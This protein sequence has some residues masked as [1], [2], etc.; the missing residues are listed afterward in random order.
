MDA[1]IAWGHGTQTDGTPDCGCSYNGVSE[2]ELMGPIASALVAELRYHGLTVG[3]D[4][5]T[6]NDRNM[7]YTVRD[8]NGGGAK[9]Y[10]SVHCDFYLAPSGTYPICHP[11]SPE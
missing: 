2:A 8:A 9:I 3:S 7:T 11:Y 4:V 10:V 1:Y 5:D 6:N